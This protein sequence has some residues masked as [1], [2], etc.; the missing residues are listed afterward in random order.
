MWYGGASSNWYLIQ[1]KID[2][3][4][5]EVIR[6]QKNIETTAMCAAFLVR[7][8]V[9][10]WTSPAKIKKNFHC[11]QTI[12]RKIRTSNCFKIIKKLKNCC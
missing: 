4:Q 8:T 2:I 3:A 7:L 5:V 12:P 1:F 6:P 9:G 11:W 10:F